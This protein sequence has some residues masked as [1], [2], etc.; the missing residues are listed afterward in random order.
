MYYDEANS[1]AVYA[2]GKKSPLVQEMQM[3]VQIKH[4][5]RTT[6]FAVICVEKGEALRVCLCLCVYTHVCAC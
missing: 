6:P 3:Q 2:D 1:V 4:V 5:Q